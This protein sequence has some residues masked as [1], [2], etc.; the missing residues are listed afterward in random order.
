[1]AVDMTPATPAEEKVA[2][3]KEIQAMR[4]PNI[5]IPLITINQAGNNAK[6]SMLTSD[7]LDCINAMKEF[8][9]IREELLK[10]R[11]ET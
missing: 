7:Y 5:P 2:Y 9:K 10:I 1:M 4:N 8:H 3:S 11:P 6:E